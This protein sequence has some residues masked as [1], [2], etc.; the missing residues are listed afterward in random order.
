MFVIPAVDIMGGRC[1]RLFKGDPKK[2]TIYF[3]DPLDVVRAFEGE[4]AKLI[5]LVDL[6]AAIGSGENSKA[7]ERVLRNVRARVQVGGGIRT[8][9][10]AKTLLELGA[11][12]VIFGTAALNDPELL[13]EAIKLFGSKQVAV[14]VDEVGN[15]VSFHGWKDV[16]DVNYLEFARRLETA[17]VGTIIFTS[18]GVDG[19]LKGPQI[20]K[21]AQLVETVKVSVI[22]S[23]GIS[24]LND[25]KEL[26]GTGV[27]GVIVGTALY[28]GKFTMKQALEVV[29][30]A[31]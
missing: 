9:K 1:V 5:H 2:R 28:E 15:R 3:D 13:A 17:G 11:S 18:T 19:T 27:E 24:S 16:S 25:L 30:H 20:E 10:R 12:R 4:G 21:I 7:I 29:K 6:D 23:G 31:S 8:L 22:A 26:A 14:A